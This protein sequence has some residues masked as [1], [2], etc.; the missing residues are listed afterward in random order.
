M[1][2]LEKL[3]LIGFKSFLS[4]TE[5]LFNEQITAV[6]GPNG[7]GKSNIAD[8]LNW[9]IGE[10]SVKSL[11]GDRMEDVI[12]NGSEGRRPLG[13]AEVSLHLKNGAD[14]GTQERLVLTRRLFR[15]GESEYLINGERT[16]LR[17]LQEALARINVGS[18]L[19][20]II[21]QGKVDVALNSRP[22]ERRILIEEAA[23]IAL[24][25]SRKRQAEAKLEATEANLLRVNDIVSELDR[26][27]GSLKRQAA[28]ARR[29]ART[30]EEITR[31]ERILLYHEHRR[32]ESGR[33]EVESR[34]SAARAMESEEAAGLA[35]IDAALEGER[36][37]LEE[38]DRIWQGRRDELHALD[39]DLDRHD[40][41]IGTAREQALQAETAGSAAREQA[42]LLAG[43]LEETA[44]LIDARRA[45]RES[46]EHGVAAAATERERLETARRDLED[47]IAGMERG[48]TELRA[49]FLQS[50]DALG[51][52]RN[53]RRQVEESEERFSRQSSALD[54]EETVARADLESRSWSRAGVEADLSRARAAIATAASE[55]ESH[56]AE[57]ARLEETLGREVAR[58]VESRHRLHGCEERLRAISEIEATTIG[59]RELLDGLA[60][61]EGILA[62]GLKAPAHVEAA[63]EIYL[64]AF[65]D[66]AL[67]GTQA[68]A[69]A[70]LASLKG[71]G[72]GRAAFLPVPADET[73]STIPAVGIPEELRSD[74]AFV[75][76][77]GELIDVD[78]ARRRALAAALA[79]AVV[80]TDLEAATRLRRLGPFFDYVTLEGDVLHTSGLIEGGAK[81]PEGAGILTRRRLK[82][83]ILQT[84]ETSRS[85]IASLDLLISGLEAERAVA[86][87]AVGS[88]SAGHALQEKSLVALSLT[89]QSSLDEE[90]RARSRLDTV[91]AEKAMAEEESGALA[92]QLERLTALQADLEVARRTREDEINASQDE[93]AATRATSA[94][95]FE[96]VSAVR[97][98]LSAARERLEALDV[99]LSRMLEADQDLRDRVARETAL[100]ADLE[101]RRREANGRESAALAAI[102][103]LTA[104]RAG[105]ESEVREGEV[106]LSRRRLEFDALGQRARIARGALEAA[107]AA[108]EQVSLEKERIH[109][110]IRHLT[111][112]AAA[113]G[114]DGAAALEEIFGAITDEEKAL[115]Q[116]AVSATLAELRDRR[117][118]L[119]PVNMLALQ[120][121]KELEERH[122]FLTAQRKDLL[123]AV[124]SLKETIARINRTSRE[125]FLDAFEKVRAGFNE[126]YRSLFG[127]GRAD[128]RL[129]TG[130]GEEDVL[131]CGMEIIAQP[132]GK[133]VQSVMLLSGGEKALTAIALLFAIFK[134]RPSPFCL[135]DEVDAPLDEANVIRFNQLLKS[136]TADT[137]FVMI[138][139]NRF[140]M[141]EADVLYGITMEEPGVSRTMSVVLGGTTDR[142]ETAKSLPALLAS[143]HRGGGRRP[144]LAATSAGPADTSGNGGGGALAEVPATPGVLPA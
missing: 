66:A 64:G 113:S 10:Q 115:A 24:Y 57:L 33:V 100:Q 13:M 80:V 87:A 30:V 140:S 35:R 65:L 9:V 45:D 23:G 122:A 69:C 12:F 133:R 49:A 86:A 32:L 139:H 72:K 142:K 121:F 95:A 15:S 56:R 17:D 114:G 40:H 37:L 44:R 28:K 96:S 42:A 3:E 90:S 1:L 138:T 36:R 48:M 59:A 29:Y 63:A 116:D 62:D 126:I 82:A 109:A 14:D 118:Q 128:L 73:Q 74:P 106:D 141:E 131:D 67:V 92:I 70:A 125:R 136:M 83:E 50:I 110:D 108:R 89:L 18:G 130:D 93:I 99:E 34:E 79:R 144:V 107:R 20:A 6:V 103:D 22:R 78:P 91:A 68:A 132:P 2:R 43:R 7:C 26:Q 60:V 19:C 52:A 85:H 84:I 27:I 105:L 31:H 55:L 127:G 76:R 81:R 111:A 94:A 98:S 75:G 71:S 38:Q 21:E 46:L 129:L 16:R 102:Q 143:R 39:R 137:Q 51:E 77:L 8:A 97:A 120:E 58:R 101:G 104:R 25:K 119:G 4:R 41:E 117:D 54:R 53:E 124:A 11:R 5:F 61:H 88:L 112:G 123:D 135:L 134:Y 47:R